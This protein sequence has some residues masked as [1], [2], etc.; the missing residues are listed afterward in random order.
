[1][2]SCPL[3]TC[4]AYVHCLPGGCTARRQSQQLALA[5]L[6]AAA[7]SAISPA[8]EGRKGHHRRRGGFHA[9]RKL[10]P[11]STI[12]K[13]AAGERLA[14]SVR[15]GPSTKQKHTAE[16]HIREHHEDK[17][18]QADRVGFPSHCRVPAPLCPIW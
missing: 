11:C 10:T 7:A 13:V 9:S 6:M 15:G 3:M 4:A 5:S 16:Q 18:R 8:R 14:S 17:S 2:S 12:P 1:M